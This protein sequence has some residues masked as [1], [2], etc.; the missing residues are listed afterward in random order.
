MELTVFQ[1]VLIGFYYWFSQIRWGYGPTWQRPLFAG[2]MCGFI[3]GD[4]TTGIKIGAII[5]PMFLAFT[6]AGGTIVWDQTAG[7]IA[8]CVITMVGGLPIDQAI[9]VALP[10]S[11]LFAQI[12]TV[13]RIWFAYPA[14][15]ADKAAAKGNDKAIIF[16]G[17]YFCW[18]SG[19][20]L[21]MLPMTL[22]MMLGAEAIGNLMSNLPKWLTN[23]LS[24]TG[25]MLPAL[26]FAMTIRVIGRPIFMPFYLGGFFLVQ[27]TGIGGMFLAMIGLFFAFL[28][29]LIL[30]ASKKD[31][32]NLADQSA[33]GAAALDENTKRLLTIK[34][35]DRMFRRWFFYCE[36]SN[37]FSRLQSVAYCISFIPA[38]KKL[39]GNDPEEYSA[40]LQRH[41]MFFNTQGI[42]GSVIHGIT[43]AMEEQRAMGAPIGADAITGIKSGLMGP[44][45]GIGDTIDWS[46]LF[47]L[48]TILVLPLAEAGNIMGP[49]LQFVLMTATLFI[50]GTIF[51]RT[52]FRLG[53]RAALN[54]LQGSAIN[55]FISVASVMGLFM[56]GGLSAS[57]VK[58]VTPI[59]IPTTGT[60]V[61][62][63]TDV[64]NKI[65]PG[66]LS[67]ATVLGTFRFLQ[68]GNSMTKATL[69]LLVIGLVAGAVGII[70]AGGLVFQ[71]YVP[72]AA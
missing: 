54:I 6:G 25:G 15:Q 8:G 47:P 42:W 9:T 40:A 53:T 48:F 16:Y 39:Y 27:Y 19:L 55:T 10:V 66:L 20:V 71:G 59:Y 46:T 18:L 64:L 63:Q 35:C 62:I 68:S 5:Q 56:M 41:L 50:E 45:A 33:A 34:D 23:A 21:Y 7:T 52:G 24:A 61:Q 29:F 65:A 12:H 26:G 22:A 44:F 11:L 17:S 38:L 30:D 13:R 72:P 67:L 1:A 60:P 69:V 43:L 31:D 37:S 58:V 3:L 36:Q 2:M 70:G 49:I 32:E 14:M 28:Y 51:S 4:L 57:M